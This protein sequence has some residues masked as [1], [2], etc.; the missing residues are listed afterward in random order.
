[1]NCM[2]IPSKMESTFNIEF[3][4]LL[5]FPPIKDFVQQRREQVHNHYLVDNNYITCQSC[6]F[7]VK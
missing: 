4:E 7:V 6:E 2:F 1:M 5:Q 3:G